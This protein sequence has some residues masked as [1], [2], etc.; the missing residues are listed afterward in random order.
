MAEAVLENGI[1]V[2]AGWFAVNVHDARWLHNGMRS[3]CRFGGE[4][5]AHFDDLGVS[6]F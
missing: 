2:T 3:V 6:L 4:G 5:D 1:P